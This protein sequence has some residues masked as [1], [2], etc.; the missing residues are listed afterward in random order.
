MLD[1]H[2]RDIAQ[3]GYFLA[4]PAIFRMYGFHGVHTHFGLYFKDKTLALG[5]K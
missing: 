5:L 3:D 1:S 4:R 2:Q